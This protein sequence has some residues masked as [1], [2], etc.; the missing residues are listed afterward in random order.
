MAQRQYAKTADLFL[1]QEMSSVH[2]WR[3]LSFH[4]KG[5]KAVRKDR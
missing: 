3:S 5:A 2:L 1:R 4:A